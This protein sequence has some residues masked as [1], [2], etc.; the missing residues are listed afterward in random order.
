[1]V[2]APSVEF[3]TNKTHKL[4]TSQTVLAALTLEKLT[5]SPEKTAK[6]A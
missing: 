5:N 4:A 3:R 1:M 2:C 6:V